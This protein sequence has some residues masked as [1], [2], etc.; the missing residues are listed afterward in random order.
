MAGGFLQAGPI[1]SRKA[2]LAISGLANLQDHFWLLKQFLAIWK[3][4]PLTLFLAVYNFGPYKSFLEAQTISDHLNLPDHFR[5]FRQVKKM[6]PKLKLVNSCAAVASRERTALLLIQKFRPLEPIMA[7]FCRCVVRQQPRILNHKRRQ[8]S[9][10][11]LSF[12]RKTE[13]RSKS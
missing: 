8:R 1:A 6:H 9:F 12:C 7:T 4:L 3:F 11:D 5:P 2:F 13:A 10:R